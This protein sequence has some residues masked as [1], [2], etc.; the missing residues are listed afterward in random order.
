MG[1]GPISLHLLRHYAGTHYLGVQDKPSQKLQPAKKTLDNTGMRHKT[2][3][4]GITTAASHIPVFI[5]SLLCS[6]SPNFVNTLYFSS[7]QVKSSH[8]LY[9]TLPHSLL[10]P[11]PFLV[12]QKPFYS[13]GVVMVV[14]TV[15]R[16]YKT[17]LVKPIISL[18][19]TL[20]VNRN[21][22]QQLL[23]IPPAPSPTHFQSHR[24][25]LKW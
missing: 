13:L 2:K 6:S 8:S 5:S 25:I 22:Q 18:S 16:N 3:C 11:T 7:C 9:L 14:S 1:L 17:L 4:P 21:L 10:H 20:A 19:T 23:C 12:Y 24:V 15:K